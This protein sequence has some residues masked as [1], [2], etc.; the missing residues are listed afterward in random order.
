MITYFAADKAGNWSSVQR[1]IEVKPDRQRPV[2]IL[3]GESE[4]IHEAVITKMLAYCLKTT[5]DN[6]SKRCCSYWRPDGMTLGE[7]TITYDY[8]DAEGMLPYR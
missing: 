8:S 4:L 2:I 3:L 5:K 1:I 7:Y 6:P